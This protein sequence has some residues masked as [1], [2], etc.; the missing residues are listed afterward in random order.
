MLIETILLH[1]YMKEFRYQMFIKKALFILY[2]DILSKSKSCSNTMFCDHRL[3]V[4]IPVLFNII[5]MLNKSSFKF[6]SYVSNIRGI[7]G[8]ITR[9][10]TTFFSF[11]LE[12]K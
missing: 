9:F 1:E 7:A 12:S 11:L 6:S 8:F 5:M 10:Y 4:T 2:H 3:V